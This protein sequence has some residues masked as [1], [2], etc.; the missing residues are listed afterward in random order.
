MNLSWSAAQWAFL[1]L[2]ALLM[3]GSLATVLR[4]LWRHRRGPA[5]A[6]I[7]ALCLCTASLYHLVGKPQAL[8]QAS[9]AQPQ[10][11][12]EAIA[13]LERQL[14]TQP[15]REGYTLLANAYNRRGQAAEARD[16]W[17]K[18]LALAPDD[19]DL[20]VAAAESRLAAAAGR[21]DERAF[22][23]LQHAIRQ[24]PDHQRARFYLGL[25]HRQQ[26]RPA[27]AAETWEP[28]LAQLPADGF[29]ALRKE[30]AAARAEAGLPPLPDTAPPTDVSAG[31]PADTTASTA[32]TVSVT[33]DPD[34]AARVRL[35]PDATVFVI[36]RAPDGPPMPV[37]VEKHRI[38]DLPLTV[39]L[40]DSDGPMPTMKLSALKQVEL[41]A[42]L[43]DSGNAMRQEGDIE[44]AP[45]RVALPSKDTVP[46]VIGAQ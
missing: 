15:D 12:D 27:E 44:S 9:L 39:T 13:M 26:G 36:A 46:L 42:R 7:V 43:S 2:A 28:L 8:D 11:L 1:V 10:T 25:G 18:A 22:E 5:A 19:P 45:V 38:A 41:V 16:T 34:F 14:A 32:L 20:L 3:V 24:S 33:L 35:R 31:T 6:L 40:D 21:Y 30:I 17:A 29:A 37:A 23:M 4:P